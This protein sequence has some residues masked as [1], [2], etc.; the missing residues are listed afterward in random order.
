MKYFM[1]KFWIAVFVLATILALFVLKGSY[2]SKGQSDQVLRFSLFSDPQ[3]MDIAHSHDAN[4]E[5]VLIQ[6]FEGLMRKD[7]NNIPQPALAEKVD[8][9]EDGKTYTFS[10]RPSLWSDGT[11]LTAYDFEYAW[12]RALNPHSKFVTRSPHYFYP[13]KNGKEALLGEVGIDEVGIRVIDENTLVVTLAYPSPYFLEILTLSLFAPIPKHIAETNPD[14]GMGYPLVSNGPFKL[15]EWKKDHRVILERNPDYWDSGHV[16]LDEID[17]F[18]IRDDH[19]TLLMFEKGELDWV[20]SPFA[21]MSYDICADILD[22]EA[23]DSL[24]Y[25]FLINNEKYPFSNKKFRQA[26]SLAINRDEVVEAVF[27]NSGVPRTSVLPATLGLAQWFPSQNATQA[28]RLFKEALQ[29]LGI[30]QK[31][32]P[33][34]KLSYVV[35]IE[36][37]HRIAQ[38]VQDQWRTILGITNVS[39]EIREWKVHFNHLFRKEYELGFLSW[40]VSVLDPS[41]ILELFR[42]KSEPNNL[43]SWESPH[44]TALLDQA[45]ECL[46]NT[47]R[48]K[49]LREAEEMIYEEMPLIPLCS[50]KKRYAKNPNLHGEYLTPIQLV[51][52]KSAY[53]EKNE[54]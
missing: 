22:K 5:H 17:I 30:T 19:T 24:I 37:H 6:L 49:Y 50:L 3:S 40:S 2:L 1:K 54:L 38:A 14:W 35:D 41:F 16:Y 20:G 45:K 28:Q 43:C 52:F 27:H 9:S 7:Q 44:Y 34:I 12:K 46:S 29:E 23:E 42:S 39:L 47:E 31:E 8:V 25:W 36:S 51:D 53:F 18:I 13:I 15:K 4:T 10:L 32:L 21:R 33:E 48:Q 11:F 26:L